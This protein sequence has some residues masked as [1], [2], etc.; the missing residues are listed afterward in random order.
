V[1]ARGPDGENG[2]VLFRY[3]TGDLLVDGTPAPGPR[4]GLFLHHPGPARWLLD[5]S[6]SALVS[7]A[8]QVALSNPS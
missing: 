7:A 3:V 8:L 1:V 2:A 5:A 6:G 4:I